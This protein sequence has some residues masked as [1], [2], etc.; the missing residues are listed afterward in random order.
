MNNQMVKNTQLTDQYDNLHTLGAELA[1]GGQGAVYRTTDADL[2]I[3]QPLDASGEPDKNA[4]LQERFQNVRL[5]P[6][7]PRIPISLP[8]AILRD[9]PGYVMRL[10]NGMKPFSAF[11]LNGEERAKLTDKKLPEWLSAIPDKKMAQDLAYYAQTG[12]TRRRLFAL[13]KCAAI[14]ARLHNAGLVYGDISK[15]NA[16][17]GENNSS[18]V[19]LIDADN[20]RLEIPTGSTVYTPH[21]GAPEIVQGKDASRPRT[22]CW[23]FAVMAFQTLALCHPFIGKK[24][25]EPDEDEGGWDAEPAANGA[26]ADLDD[27]AYAGFLPWIDDEDD[28]SNAFPNGGLPRSLVLT[29]QLR[30]L[31]QETFGA[32]RTQPYRRPAMLFWALELARAFDATIDCPSCKMSYYTAYSEDEHKQCPYCKTPRPAFAVAQ[33][34]R[35]KTNLLAAGETPLPHRLFA[36]FS[37]EHSDS[38]EYEAVINLDKQTIV[39]VRG[40]KSFPPELTFLF[41][42]VTK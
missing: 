38:P 17:I 20:L 28:D 11:S 42:E 8:L 13:Y 2:A 39:P 10:L 26:P 7:P 22:D 16:F 24:V 18:E 1:R 12:S 14:L 15:N 36:P 40:I 29:P 3:K 4:K 32:G 34:K 21:L 37:L 41:K 33:T 25:L 5:L 31:F 19:W 30:R 6:L 27:Q 23:A 35:W 9:E